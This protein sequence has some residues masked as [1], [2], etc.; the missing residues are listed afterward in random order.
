MHSQLKEWQSQSCGQ[1]KNKWF[2]GR[3]WMGQF[4]WSA[5]LC[6]VRQEREVEGKLWREVNFSLEA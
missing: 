3:V 5:D 1:G 4:S 2:W 6:P